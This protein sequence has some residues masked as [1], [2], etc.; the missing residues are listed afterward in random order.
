MTLATVGHV[1]VAQVMVAPWAIGVGFAGVLAVAWVL[2]GAERSLATILGGLLGGQFAFHAMFTAAQPGPSIMD[3]SGPPTLMT[4]GHGGTAMTL[5]H[6]MAAVVSAWWLRRGE[7]AVWKLARRVAALA[8]RS[9]WARWA[10]PDSVP[11]V[12][13]TPAFSPVNPPIRPRSAA[14]RHSVV[15]RGPPLRPTALAR[16]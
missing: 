15:R 14:L 7:R 16:G 9:I 12:P 2:T 5:A 6:V 8:D 4:G 11:S 10:L 3:H 1:V 13:L